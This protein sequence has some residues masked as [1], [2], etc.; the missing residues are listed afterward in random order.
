VL[1]A[2]SVE[3]NVRHLFFSCPFS[4]ACWTYLGVIWDLSLDFQP[5]VFQERLHFDASFFREVFI[6]GCWALWCHQNDIIF[7]G[8]S[9]SFSSW[10][11]FF[12]K[13][14]RAVTLRVKPQLGDRINLWLSNIH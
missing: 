5:M 11:F 1:C 13:E 8:S 6:I 10:K 9:L 14:L 3:E 2:S 7:D 12:V 4:D